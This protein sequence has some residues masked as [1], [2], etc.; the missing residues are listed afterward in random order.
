MQRRC[1]NVS[2]VLWVLVG[3][4]F[5]AASLFGAWSIGQRALAQH[6]ADSQP[7]YSVEQSATATTF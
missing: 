7:S 4:A 2:P 1:G 6:D 3:L 5:G